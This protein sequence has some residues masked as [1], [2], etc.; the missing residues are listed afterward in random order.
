MTSGTTSERSPARPEEPAAQIAACERTFRRYGLPLLVHGHT[1][2]RDVYGRAAPF[3]VV[4]MLLEVFAAVRLDWAWWVNLAVLVGAIGLLFAGYAGLNVLRGRPWGTLPQDVGTA[5]LVFFVLAPAVLPVVFGGQWITG[6]SVAVGN[7]V[8]LAIVRGVVGYGLAA[9]LWWGMSRVGKELGDSLLRLIRFLPLL[10]I[11]SIALFYTTEVWQ[12]FDHTPGASDLILGAFFVALI[13][14]ILRI[15][16]S[17]ETE[18]ILDRAEREV[19]EVAALPALT[20]PQRANVA[21][22]VGAN[23]LLQV[24][25]VSLGVG[26][27][28]LALGV[29][30]ITPGLMAEWAIDG[31]SWREEVNLFGDT[32]VLSQTLIRVS[33]AMATFTGLYYAIS[34]LT[35]AVYRVD[36]IDDMAVK[37]ADVAAHRVRYRRLL[38]ARDAAGSG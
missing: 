16:L 34:V 25:V 2:R 27:F 13:V 32:L 20:R 38:A 22:M 4:V 17:R 35:D 10:L 24:I 7:V 28:F 6:L 1:S 21:A 5:E 29:L 19:P 11:F 8:L 23:Q 37:M 15:R 30:T 18:E 31:G 3:L 33:V 12:V 14:L 9:T 36:F 26:V